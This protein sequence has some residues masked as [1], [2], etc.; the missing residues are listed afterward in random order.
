MSTIRNFPLSTLEPVFR[1]LGAECAMPVHVV[2]GTRDV[3]VPF[4]N[5]PKLLALVPRAS[6]LVLD[7][8]G[9]TEMFAKFYST[10]RSDL[11]AFLHTPAEHEAVAV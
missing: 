10:L 5:Q 2:W 6:A 1:R 9:H 8:C 7:D 11:L 4:S 3:V